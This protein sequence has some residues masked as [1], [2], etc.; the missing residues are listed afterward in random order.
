MMQLATEITTFTCIC[1]PLGCQLEAAFDERGGVAE[2]SGNTC[3]RGAEYAKR[4]ATAP[5]SVKTASPVPKARVA[6]VLAA[7]LSAH[8]AAPVAAGDVVVADA[9]GT[10]VDVV[11]TKSVP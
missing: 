4:E 5:V 10:G 7:C 8:L 6:D 9:C 1:C 3:G 2:V 11:A